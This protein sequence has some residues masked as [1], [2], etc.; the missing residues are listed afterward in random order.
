MDH[1]LSAADLGG[2]KFRDGNFEEIWSPAGDWYGDGVCL[3][4][5]NHW[6]HTYANRDYTRE[7]I[8]YVT[9]GVVRYELTTIL[10]D[11]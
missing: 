4:A 6:M 8:I 10:S 1:L 5:G 9:D 2:W 7:F 3:R 11:E